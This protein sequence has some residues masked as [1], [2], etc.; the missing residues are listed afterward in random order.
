MHSHA[1]RIAIAERR[2]PLR[3]C[4][5]PT[6]HIAQVSDTDWDLVALIA[7]PQVKIPLHAVDAADIAAALVQR[8]RE[9][10]I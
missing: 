9:R 8:L 4:R 7:Q 6:P 2:L 10:L 3:G 5:P 1:L